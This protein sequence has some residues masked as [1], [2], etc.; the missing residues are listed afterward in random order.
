LYLRAGAI[1]VVLYFT[2]PHLGA[3]LEP[4]FAYLKY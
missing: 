2:L 3:A 4:R 1:Y